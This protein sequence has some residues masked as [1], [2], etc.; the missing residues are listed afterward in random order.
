MKAASATICGTGGDGVSAGP[1]HAAGPGAAPGR[2]VRAIFTAHHA[3]RGKARSSGS[4]VGPAALPGRCPAG[5]APRDGPSSRPAALPGRCP[6]G[7][8]PR[9]GP[10]SRPA[11]L[12][13]RC[14]AGLA[15]RDGPSSRGDPGADP[16]GDPGAI[17]SAEPAPPQSA[18]GAEE[19]MGRRRKGRSGAEPGP[20]RVRAAA[21]WAMWRRG[22]AWAWGQRGAG[23]AVPGP[24]AGGPRAATGRFEGTF[25][26]VEECSRSQYT[27]LNVPGCIEVGNNSA[28]LCPANHAGAAHQAHDFPH[29]DDGAVDSQCKTRFCG[30]LVSK[31]KN[32]RGG[33]CCPE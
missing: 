19:V 25:D 22:A 27:G 14:P 7:L 32:A 30:K 9:D 6:A 20:V 16:A 33:L 3:E 26:Q 5:L 2:T 13:G 10:S 12:P 11:A 23:S 8:A 18:S 4:R 15:P 28:D 24:S 17:A 29:K 21:G 31:G 1:G